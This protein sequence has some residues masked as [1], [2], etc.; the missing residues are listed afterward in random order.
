M[1]TGATGPDGIPCKSAYLFLAQG[2]PLPNAITVSCLMPTFARHHLLPRAVDMFLAQQRPGAELLIVSEDGLPDALADR[3]AGVRHIPCAAGLSLG[4][5]RNLAC[6]AARGGILVH[7]DDDDLQAADRLARQFAAFNS[8][9]VQVSGSSLAHFREASTGLCWEYRYRDRTR[10]WVCGA[11]LA[12]TREYWLRHPFADVTIGEDNRF[13]WAANADEFHDL[14]DAGLCLCTIH[15]G[16]TSVKNTADAWWR[17]IE[18][19]ARWQGLITPA[20]RRA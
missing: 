17:L 6:E 19:P 11:T 8:G 20:D 4:A 15:D 16:N 5:K 3:H 18:L 10:P 2:S 1:H 9:R 14:N 13:V 12:Y 7:W